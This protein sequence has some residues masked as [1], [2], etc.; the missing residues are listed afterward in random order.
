MS[1]QPIETA[2]KDGCEIIAFIPNVEIPSFM[3]AGYENHNRIYYPSVR[4]VRWKMSWYGDNSK[5]GWM[6]ANLDEE[7]GDYVFP[8]HWT[9]MPAVPESDAV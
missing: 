6:P 3:R 4:S 7:H 8:S 9:A 1:W 2:P 5:P